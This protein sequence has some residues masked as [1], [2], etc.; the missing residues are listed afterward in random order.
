MK[1]KL[2]LGVILGLTCSAAAEARNDWYLYGA[3]P[4]TGDHVLEAAYRAALDH[5][6]F[7]GYRVNERV[8]FYGGAYGSADVRRC[9]SRKGFVWQDGEPYAYPVR[10]AAYHLR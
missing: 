1:L 7:E 9:L 4:V 5:C 6:N 2:A 8:N 10:K 3:V